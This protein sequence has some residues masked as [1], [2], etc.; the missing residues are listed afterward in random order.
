MIVPSLVCRCLAALA[1]SATA[2]S[3]AGQETPDTG[4]PTVTIDLVNGQTFSGEVDPRTGPERLWLRAE[5]GSAAVIRPIRWDRIAR[6]NVAGQNLS[7]DQF[8][9]VVGI[10]RHGL[11]SPVDNP[12]RPTTIVLKGQP[13]GDWPESSPSPQKPP[14][15]R[16]VRNVAIDASV[17]TWGDQVGPDGLVIQVQPRDARGAVVP[18]WGTLEV[19]LIGMRLGVVQPPQP[20][21]RLGWWTQEVRPEDFVDSPGGAVYGLPF[22]AVQPE[23][24]TNVAP[25]A[26]V[27]VR[28]SVPGQGTFAATRSSVRIR[29]TSVVRDQLQR[30]SGQRYFP[31]E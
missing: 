14:A 23:L 6:A 3:V 13:Y 11:P 20:F 25:H 30:A 29:P 28:L 15:P 7:G 8:Q 9:H 4:K 27:L 18:V 19:E 31:G 2:H 5:R 26:A 12:A 1:V 10:L 24:D 17:G 21:E 22:Q 16:P